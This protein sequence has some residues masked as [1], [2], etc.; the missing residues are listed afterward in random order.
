MISIAAILVFALVPAV[1]AA[2]CSA[3]VYTENVTDGRIQRQA[4]NVT[5]LDLRN[6]EG[7]GGSTSN[8]YSYAR[9]YSDDQTNLYYGMERGVIVFDTSVLPDDATI[10]SAKIGL[11][12]Y[13]NQTYLGDTGVSLTK[14]NIN[15]SIDYFDYQD[16]DHIKLA[17]EKN[18]STL[19]TG[20][21]H[22]FTLNA[23]G[24]SNVSLT[25]FSG[26]GVRTAFDVD[27]I[28]PTW[29]HVATTQIRYYTADNVVNIPLMDISYTNATCSAGGAPVASFTSDVSA[30]A[31]SASGYLH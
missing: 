25:D 1:S 30:G 29:A 22:N 11:Y 3:T 17:E 4:N 26:F 28:S 10:T 13:E 16:F 6:G 8:N 14:F 5:F 19:R 9:I 20:Q 27:N 31:C 12:I 23:L 7:T 18:I 24:L 15:G 21:Y 2:V